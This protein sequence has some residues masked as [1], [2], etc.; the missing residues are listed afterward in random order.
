MVQTQELTIEDL[1]DRFSLQMTEDPHFFSEW[2]VSS[3]EL[4]DHEQRALDRIKG[5]FLAQL[6]GGLLAEGLVKLIVLAPLLDLAGFYQPP[7]RVE[8]EEPIV[9]EAEDQGGVIRGRIDIL[10]VCRKIWIVII[11]AKHYRFSLYEGMT[12]LLQ[13]MVARSDQD[14]PQFGLITNGGEFLFAKLIKSETSLYAFSNLF[15]LQNRGNDLYQVLSIL[16][17]L[18]SLI[19][20]QDR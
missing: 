15:S 6:R 4:T 2:E 16:K 14:Q 13:Y 10:V 9:I 3:V 1:E 11:E 5:N 7:F 12:Q 18:G 20:S 8:V 19:S 17:R